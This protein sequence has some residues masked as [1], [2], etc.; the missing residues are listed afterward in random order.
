[1][2]ASTLRVVLDPAAGPSTLFPVRAQIRAWLQDAGVVGRE[3]DEFVIAIGEACANVIEHSGAQAAGG[4][5][6]GWIECSADSTH[7]RVVVRDRGRWRPPDPVADAPRN[8][9]RGRSIMAALA[10][11]MSISTGS[12]GTA[13]E[14]VKERKVSNTAHGSTEP[15]AAG[16]RLRIERPRAGEVVLAG[17]ID[18]TQ[19]EAL[20]AELEAAAGEAAELLIDLR[21]VNYLDSA[22]VSVLVDQTRRPLRLLVRAGSAVATVITIC[23]L[24]GLAQVEFVTPAG[25]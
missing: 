4:H 24:P 12:D 15:P 25:P 6:A 8:R 3:L 20:R 23:G 16:P 9:G 18:M 22:G 19:T 13:V 2:S 10:D 1:M 21:A 5:E 7:V 14:L 11:R 17:E